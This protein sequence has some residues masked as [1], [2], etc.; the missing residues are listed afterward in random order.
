M[1]ALDIRR[2]GVELLTP[3]FTAHGFAY[4]P[5][6]ADNGSGGFFA[7]GAFVRDNR[8]LEFSTRY[9]LGEVVYRV[10]DRWLAHED[11]MRVTAGRGNHRYPGFSDD[12]LDAFRDLAADLNQFGGSF[13][14]GDDIAFGA[15]IA[16]AE[17]TR[18]PRGFA[19]LSRSPAS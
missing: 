6:L 15:V 16:E 13:F 12:P 11:F 8:R 3:L 14:T 10:G 1:D 7:R 19:A 17:R 9:T 18:P 4:E 5:G 2:R